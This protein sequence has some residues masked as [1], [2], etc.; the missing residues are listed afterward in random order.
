MPK[1]KKDQKEFVVSVTYHKKRGSQCYLPKPMLEILGNPKR[2][3]FIV[4][5][6]SI[7]IE[8]GE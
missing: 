4:K 3:R 1:W 5:S 2:I 6:K 7:E 8:A